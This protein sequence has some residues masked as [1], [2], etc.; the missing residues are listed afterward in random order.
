MHEIENVIE[1]YFESWNQ[2]FKTKDDSEIR[3]YLSSDFMGYWSQA[4]MREPYSY[5][6]EI[7][8]AASLKE[9]GNGIKEYQHF[10]LSER[11]GGNEVVTIG[12]ETN[13]INNETHKAQS[14][15]VWRKE[16]NQWKLLREYIEI[17]GN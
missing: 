7:D 1:S 2:G 16:S 10:H 4:G 11:D 9:M 14:M 12:I 5:G 8:L 3:S 6:R 15:F 17:E 13:I